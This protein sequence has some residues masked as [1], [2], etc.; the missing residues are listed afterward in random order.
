MTFGYGRSG[1][2]NLRWII[3]LVIAGVGLVTYFSRTQI[4]P[5]TGEK[6]H[7]SMTADQEKA[8]GLQAAPKMAAQMGGWLDPKTSPAARAVA[9]VGQRLA[10][11]SEAS[12]S[13]YTGNFHYFLLNDTATLNAFALPGGQIFITRA[14][15]D[16]LKTESEL[17]GVLGHETGHVIGRHS[18][19]QMAK[20]QLGQT[21]VVATGVGA[22]GDRNGQMAT[23]A[24]MMANQML[25]LKYSRGDESEAD[26]FGV[27][28]MSQAGY[29]PRGI[30]RVMQVLQEASKGGRQPEFMSSHPDPG[31][32]LQRLE[33]LIKQGFP[34]G[35]PSDLTEGNPLPPTGS[36]SAG[37]GNNPRSSDW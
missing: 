16:K 37:T 3:A 14:L 17:A 8:L 20:G 11:R 35:I 25:S 15:Y 18:A 13:P 24:A 29:D 30:L 22:S 28:Y 32:R 23:I 36:G 34:N 33:E 21:L 2:F 9:A 12:K 26:A 31:N 10:E 5:V 19:E 27:K 1:G 4:N 6:Q 7:I